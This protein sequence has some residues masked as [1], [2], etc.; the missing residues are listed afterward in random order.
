MPHVDAE[1]PGSA[2]AWPGYHTRLEIVQGSGAD[3][4]LRALRDR[5]QYHDPSGEA[6]RAGIPPASWPLFGL[7]WPS[8]QAL[9][10][11]MMTF[12]LDGQRVLEV[13][14]GLALASLVVHRRGGDVTA[15]DCHPLTGHFLRENLQ[16]NQLPPMKY[17]TG[18]WRTPNP[19]LDRFDL[20]I[21]SDVL[22]DRG[23]PE[24]LSRFIDLHAHADAQVLIVDPDRGNQAGFTRCMVGLGYVHSTQRLVGLPDGAVYKGRLLRYS[25]APL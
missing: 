11:L 8:A 18:N 19:G 20:I 15:S 3:I 17:E 24:L 12:N 5:M 25:R 6:E 23:Q 13:G 7:L 4:R 22:Y 10:G 1:G 9:A 21:G 16:L 14:C 2:L